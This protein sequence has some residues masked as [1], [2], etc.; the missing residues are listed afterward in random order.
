MEKDNERA[1]A[2]YEKLGLH[3]TDYQLLE[4]DWVL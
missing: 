3:T 2:T 4:T 1:R